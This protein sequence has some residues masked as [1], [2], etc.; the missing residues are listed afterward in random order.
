MHAICTHQPEVRATA[1]DEDAPKLV[2]HIALEN[3]QHRTTHI[4]S[5]KI[6]PVRFSPACDLHDGLSST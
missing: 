1:G 5:D 3:E 2:N 4:L 6:R